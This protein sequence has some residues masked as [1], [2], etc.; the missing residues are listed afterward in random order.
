MLFV[1]IVFVILTLIGIFT[2]VVSCYC[3]DVFSWDVFFATIFFGFITLFCTI[4]YRC[5]VVDE[6]STNVEI[7]A[8]ERRLDG[9]TYV[10]ST[11]SVVDITNGV[12]VGNGVQLLTD[13]QIIEKCS[14]D[15]IDNTKRNG[16]KFP[17]YKLS[18]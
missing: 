7:S 2:G 11:N 9:T 10:Y 14:I 6:V 18:Y 15:V 12:R 16:D 13:E 4:V 5:E 1:L 8:V 17:T 3:G